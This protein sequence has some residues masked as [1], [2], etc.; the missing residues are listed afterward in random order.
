MYGFPP[1]PL[2]ITSDLVFLALDLCKNDDAIFSFGEPVVSPRSLHHLWAGYDEPKT[3]WQHSVRGAGRTKH[4]VPLFFEYL[5]GMGEACE[6]YLE[7]YCS[8]G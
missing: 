7:M 5:S 6:Q 2:T 8:I 4:R 3:I 1:T